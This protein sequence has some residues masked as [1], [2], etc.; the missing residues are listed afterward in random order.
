MTDTA[1]PLSVLDL[2]P[3][4]TGRTASDALLET[5]TLAQHTESLGYERF[6]VAEHHNI[7]S[8]ASSSP[9]VMIATLAA[10]TS[11]I[12]V[13]AGGIMLPNHAPLQ[14]AE[15]FRVLE[16]LHPGRIDLGLGRAPG[17]DQLTALALRRS[18]EALTANDFP[19][20]FAELR[21]YVDGFPDDH[22][23]APISAQPTDVPLPPVWILGSSMYGAQAAGLLGTNF[24]FAGHFGSVDPREAFDAYR[25]S[26]TPNGR[27]DCPQEPHSMLAVSAIAAE[28]TERASELERAAALSTVR[29]RQNNPGPLPSPEEAAAHEWTE[30]EQHLVDSLGRF[31]TA[32][33]A[34][35]V[36]DGITARARSCG[37][38]ELMITTNVHDAAERRASYTLIAEAARAA[39]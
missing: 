38:D 6:W 19:Q 37:A 32:G 3:I 16:A 24:A 8:V 21:A 9:V 25:S 34:E 13:G 14:V 11:T 36:Y 15:T 23:F 20:Q 2:S 4:S 28:S 33:T 10:A 26:F 22:P 29:L 17:T 12:R 5:I 18:K 27:A 1:I 35:A 31:V 30:V 39:H 7:P